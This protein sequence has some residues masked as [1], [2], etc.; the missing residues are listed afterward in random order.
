MLSYKPIQHHIIRTPLLP[1][2]KIRHIVSNTI[3]KKTLCQICSDKAVMEALFLA[4]PSLYKEVLKWLECK[5]P[6]E[7]EENK[8][9]QG[10]Y[11][12]FAR[13]CTRCTPFGMFAGIATGTI[14]DKTDIFLSP[15]EKNKLHVRLDMNYVC[16][17]AKDLAEIPEIKE[18]ILFYPNNSLYRI[19]DKIRYVEYTFKNAMRSHH[20]SA[21]DA[22]EYLLK[23]VN[24]AKQGKR[25][26]DLANLVVDDEVTIDDAKEF[27][28]E[29][30]DAQVLTSELEPTVIGIDPLEQMIAVLDKYSDNKAV[31]DIICKLANINVSLKSI[32]DKAENSENNLEQYEN[33][34]KQLSEF[35]TTYDEKFLFQADMLLKPVVNTVSSGISDSIYKT[36]EFLN[37]ITPYF[38][39]D[40]L[41]NFK[42][43]FYSRYEEEEV[44][45]AHALDTESGIGYLQNT[46]NG[47]TPLVDD[48]FFP[49]MI[50]NYQ[51][52]ITLPHHVVM[53]QK[54]SEAL[55]C[56]KKEICID[57]S[58]FEGFEA[59]WDDIP[60]TI[61]AFVQ[62][63]DSK[64]FY[65]RSIGGSCAANLIGRFCHLDNSI[66]EHTKEI[67]H[68]DEAD[69]D[70]IYAEIVHLPEY[71]I[72]NILHRPTIRNYEIPYLAQSSLTID[73]QLPLD[74]LMV[75]VRG[76]RILLRSKKH[77]K[78]VI[79]R[80]TTAHNFSYNA[81]PVYQFLCDMQNC[82]KRGGFGFSWGSIE[83]T[84]PYLPRVVYGDAIL[85][86]ETW[87]FFKKDID[88]LNKIKDTDERIDKFMEMVKKR[89][90]TDE[91]ILEDNDND[92]YLN[93]TNRFCVAVLLEFIRKRYSFTLKEFPFSND[94]SP[95]KASDECF[96]N[97]MLFAYYKNTEKQ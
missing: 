46:Y 12:Y 93:L 15:K 56:H 70:C 66:L 11:R 76:N 61:S 19:G 45:L 30:V 64:H 51:S 3:T 88:T 96:A 58:D 85:S 17:L 7:K 1:M 27:I 21:V 79:P 4:S 90:I 53:Q 22:S 72:G 89:N 28:D 47:I 73:N 29:M 24:E 23:V 42:E 13:M 26:N 77:N 86:L 44:P 80:L 59:K 39:N 83:N 92:L 74:D 37:R 78:L 69:K 52:S 41:K 54:L 38:E 9:M 2:D 60:E 68:K 84:M 82:D 6:N 81:L 40:N 95:V 71:R 31:S 63:I 48:V 18:Q 75:S 50:Q 94:K 16:A 87:N 57:E 20:I 32:R 67:I 55:T 33:I 97:E 65:V 36:M 35:S 62:I 14:S 5:M 43:A 10:L 8:V 49:P 34:K 91:V 25:L